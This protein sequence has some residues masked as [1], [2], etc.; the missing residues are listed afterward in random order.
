MAPKAAN[1][2][3]EGL[4]L[5]TGGIMDILFGKPGLNCIVQRAKSLLAWTNP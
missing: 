5:T 1:L 4:Q 3:V 2:F